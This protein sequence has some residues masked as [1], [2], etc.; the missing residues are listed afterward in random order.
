MSRLIAGALAVG[1]VAAPGWVEID[2][3]HVVGAGHGPP[4]RTPDERLDGILSRGLCDLQ[5]NGAAGHE[6]TDGAAALDT[7]DAVQLAHGVTSYLP[8]LVSPD[9]AIAERV[10]EELGRR[11]LDTASPVAGVHVEG[12]FL[13]P[14]HAGMHPPER[15]RVPADGV[16]A[17]LDHPAVR[18]VTLAPELP[19]ALELIARLRSRGVAVALGHS[20]ASAEVARAAIDAGAGLVTHVFNA[21]APLHHREPGLAGV[22][23]VDDRVQVMAIA[24]GHH[25]HPLVL[26]LVRRAAGRRTLLAT[27][28]TP[29]AGAPRGRFEM[30]GVTIETADDGSARTPEGRLAGSTLTLDEAARN[31][32]AMT[33]ATLAQALF[34]ASEAPAAAAGIAGTLRFGAPADLVLVDAAGCVRRVMRH[35]RWIDR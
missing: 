20:G 10:L 12:P 29:A 34:A 17:W 25:L 33:G 16:P 2:G 15:L 14:S 3:E 30:A 21:M 9:D 13:S 32:S 5:V 26:E 1:G 23:L 11:A 35:G 22:T 7:I 24:D 27:D 28:A 8:T 6:V 19:G 4:P 18:I 31:W